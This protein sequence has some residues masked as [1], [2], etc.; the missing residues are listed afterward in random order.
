LG[1]EEARREIIMDHLHHPRHQGILLDAAG[2]A[3]GLNPGCHDEVTFYVD[4]DD[5]G[6]LRVRFMGQ[7]CALSQ[8]SASALSELLQGRPSEQAEALA[9][10]FCAA[11]SGDSGEALEPADWGDVAA[12]EGARGYPQRVKCATL[13]WRVFLAALRGEADVRLD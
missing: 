7:G 6:R 5:E 9:E 4:R 1:S 10:R 13:A 2:T 11:L 8:A 3:S 12:L